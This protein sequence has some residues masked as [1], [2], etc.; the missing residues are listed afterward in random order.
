MEMKKKKTAI[1]LFQ[2]ITYKLKLILKYQ[3]KV[4][5]M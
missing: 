3:N 5:L 1:N 2:L 4:F